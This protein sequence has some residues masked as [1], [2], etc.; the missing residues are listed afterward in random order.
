MNQANEKGD[1]NLSLYM[2]M[3]NEYLIQPK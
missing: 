1:M 3:E 2:T